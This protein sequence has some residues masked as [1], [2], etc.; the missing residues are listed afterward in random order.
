MPKL[1]CNGVIRDMTEEE[2]RA[3]EEYFNS[4]AYR[5]DMETAVRKGRDRRLI[6]MDAVVSNPLRWASLTEE[7][8]QAWVVYRQALLDVPQQEG[9]PTDVTWPTKPE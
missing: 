2:V 5:I 1:I 3:N 4:E 9:F 6:E 7:Q 8:Q